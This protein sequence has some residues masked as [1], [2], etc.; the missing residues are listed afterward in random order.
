MNQTPT[1]QWC[2]R[3][4]SP[5]IFRLLTHLN[6]Y[7]SKRL[8]RIQAPPRVVPEKPLTRGLTRHHGSRAGNRGADPQPAEESGLGAALDLQAGG[9]AGVNK[10]LTNTN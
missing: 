7:G 8:T 5:L 1:L 2:R 9:E 10:R 6:E 3:K 4:I